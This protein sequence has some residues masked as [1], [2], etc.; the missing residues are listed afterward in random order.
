MKIN[1]YSK[2]MRFLTSDEGDYSPNAPD[3][4]VQEKPDYRMPSIEQG[5]ADGGSVETPKRGLVDE[6]GSYAGKP[7]IGD[8]TT[9]GVNKLYKKMI[10]ITRI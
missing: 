6:P 4:F 10:F 2:G 7:L 3:I 1:E 5:F 9:K 8:G